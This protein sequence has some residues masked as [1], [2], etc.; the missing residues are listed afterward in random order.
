MRLRNP[1]IITQANLS[2]STSSQNGVNPASGMVLIVVNS[3]A[4]VFSS[5]IEKDVRNVIWQVDE[6][7]IPFSQDVDAPNLK[8]KNVAPVV[9]LYSTIWRHINP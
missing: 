3:H 1:P 9:R 5:T 7:D 4:F 8:M 2:T 6:Q